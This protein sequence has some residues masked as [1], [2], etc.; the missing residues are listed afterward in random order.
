MSSKSKESA[1]EARAPRNL[2]AKFYRAVDGSQPVDDFIE[3]LLAAEQ[4]IIDAQINRLNMLDE[5]HTQLAFP[6]SSQVRGTLRELRCHYGRTLYRI[7]YRQSGHFVVLLHMIRKTTG[8]IPEAD[9]KTAE[10]RWADYEA[11]FEAVP[12]ARPRAS[13]ND[14]PRKRRR[15]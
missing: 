11:R 3:S 5:E 2:I 9:V 7:L 1:E 8:T 13:G 12:R 4:V 14:A 10:A 6:H 15:A